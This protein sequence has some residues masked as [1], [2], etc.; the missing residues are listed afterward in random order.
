MDQP[1][2]SEHKIALSTCVLCNQ[3]YWITDLHNEPLYCR[4][5]MARIELHVSADSVV[6]IADVA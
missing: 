1:P 3:T 5:C 2:F 6:D 4:D